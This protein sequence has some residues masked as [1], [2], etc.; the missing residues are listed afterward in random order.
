MPEYASARI[1]RKN[2]LLTDLDTVRDREKRDNDA[3]HCEQVKPCIRAC[4]FRGFGAFRGH[5]RGFAT[6]RE[7]AK[8][9][10]FDR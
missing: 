6:G 8:W 3:E 2:V 1:E 7:G 10:R 5:C 4:A 9:H